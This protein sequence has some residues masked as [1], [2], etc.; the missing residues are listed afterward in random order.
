M[1]VTENAVKI[2]RGL[3]GSAI[4]DL[5][6]DAHPY[7]DTAIDFA[8]VARAAGYEVAFED[9]DR[10]GRTY[11]G[12]KAADLWLPVIQVGVDLL[13]GMT[14]G[15]LT[16][17]LQRW[18]D[19]RRLESSILHVDYRI[20]GRDGTAQSI[21]ISGKGAEV[22][23]ALDAFERREIERAREEASGDSQEGAEPGPDNP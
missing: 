14:G 20:I 17:I 9:P 19:R 18:M 12:R 22:L 2:L 13:V 15:L 11:I 21:Q 7:P 16:N 1:I 6:R 8:K 4:P 3:P 23:R 5:P 10:N